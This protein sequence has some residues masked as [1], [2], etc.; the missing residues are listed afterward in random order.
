[1]QRTKEAKLQDLLLDCI[2]SSEHAINSSEVV[3]A[4]EKVV[5]LAFRLVVLLQVG[6]LTEVAHL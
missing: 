2:C 1:M 6:T 4:R 5:D 3:G